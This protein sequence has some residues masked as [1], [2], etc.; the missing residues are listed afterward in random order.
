MGQ[1]YTAA[2][3]VFGYGCLETT[4]PPSP[5][6]PADNPFVEQ[7]TEMM[8]MVGNSDN[9]QS[10]YQGFSSEDEGLNWEKAHKQEEKESHIGQ[11][12]MAGAILGSKESYLKVTELLSVKGKNKK[13]YHHSQQPLP[14]VVY[15]HKN[16]QGPGKWEKKRNLQQRADEKEKDE[17]RRESALKFMASLPISER[18]P[19]LPLSVVEMHCP[20]SLLLTI[21][22]FGP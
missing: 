21:Q 5:L 9:P 1:G 4:P 14:E 16:W 12:L 15:L 3:Q 8:D 6:L 10:L 18:P 11:M 2:S 17:Q 7:I 20:V 22:M 13:G 19:D